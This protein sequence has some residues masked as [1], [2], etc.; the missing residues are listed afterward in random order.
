VSESNRDLKTFLTIRREAFSDDPAML[1]F[2]D[3][4]L[5]HLETPPPV[6]GERIG[7]I[8][9]PEVF[10]ADGEFGDPK[11]CQLKRGHRFAHVF[12]KDDLPPPSSGA[13]VA[14]LRALLND[15]SPKWLG[16][17]FDRY[18]ENDDVQ[19]DVYEEDYRGSGFCD[20]NSILIHVCTDTRDWNAAKE[21]RGAKMAK[22][23]VA[24]VNALPALLDE[25]DRLREVERAAREATDCFRCGTYDEGCAVCRDSRTP[26]VADALRK[27]D[28]LRASSPSG[29]GR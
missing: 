3:G 15:L 26:A 27:L 8:R 6:E 16:T 12:R 22:L 17:D 4:I 23:I 21:S 28:A 14:E 20:P 2:I 25:I 24:A 9:C 11:P 1:Q 18:D 29:G 10:D 19:A 7:E 13:D 5:R